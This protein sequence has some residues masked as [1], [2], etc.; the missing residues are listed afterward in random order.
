MWNDNLNSALGS[1][2]FQLIADPKQAMEAFMSGL[3]VANAK[4]FKKSGNKV[5]INTEPNRP[6]WNVK[7]RKLVKRAQEALTEWK[8]NPLSTEKRAAWR[9]AEALKK[10]GIIAAK[11][12]AWKE[13][14][15][16]LGP[17]DQPKLWSFVKCMLGKGSNG[18]INGTEIQWNGI[19]T[20][21]PKEKSEIFAD[22]FI[23][24]HPANIPPNPQFEEQTYAQ[25]SSE[26]TAE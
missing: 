10:R 3:E 2:N 21:D 11:R 26:T 7:C 14:I 1:K 17:Q 4:N 18:S 6:W 9:K 16:G 20:D 24:A 12:E 23:K 22:I 15:T 19:T 5:R 25:I 8:R 13:Y